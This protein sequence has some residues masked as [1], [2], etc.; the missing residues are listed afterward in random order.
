MFTLAPAIVLIATLFTNVPQSLLLWA[1]M[2]A[3]AHVLWLVAVYHRMHVSPLYAFISPLGALVVLY[4][5]ARA[6]SR[7]Q[8]V[9][10]KDRV[11]VSR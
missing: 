6:A 9:M 10:W 2:A 8:R 5:F 3:I 1:I 7:G 4:I 11:Y